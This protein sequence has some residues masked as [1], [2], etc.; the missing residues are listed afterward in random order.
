[1]TQ[2][3]GNRPIDRLRE[4]PG[5]AE[6]PPGH[7]SIISMKVIGDRMYFLA[8]R[9][10][11]S[12]VMADQ[13]DPERTNPRIPFVIQRVEIPYGVEHPFMQKTVCVAFELINQT[14]LQN[15]ID[16]DECLTLAVSNAISLASVMDVVNEMIG[17]QGAT[18]AAGKAG[19][20][21]AGHL[22]H[23]LNL[24]SKVHQ[25]LAALRDVEVAIKKTVS[26]FYPKEA[27]N[28]AWDKK[29]K[30]ELISSR[31]KTEGF[32][33]HVNMIWKVMEEVADHRHAMIHADETKSLKIYDYE[34]D[35]KGAFVAPT[36]EILHP[37]SPVARRDTAQFLES[38]TMKIANV[39][40]NL[41]GYLCDLNA[42]EP[43]VKF[44]HHVTSLPAEQ[45]RHGSKLVW[46]TKIRDGEAFP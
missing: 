45:R 36:I 24:K 22:P 5:R 6:I 46:T 44:E 39:Y 1:M 18:R 25:S 7:G 31:D 20:L 37:R 38:Q 43:S 23:T 29:F 11:T 42:R 27:P 41:L 15:D 33:D 3:P 40:E 4:G 32:V 10:F 28:D 34:L 30:A 9:G 19:K 8:E 26:K 14:Y 35:P 2:K 16:V 13:I 12:G 21:S 17:H